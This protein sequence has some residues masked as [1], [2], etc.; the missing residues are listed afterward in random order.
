MATQIFG[1]LLYLPE[2]TCLREFPSPESLKNKIII[3]TK[4]PKEYL[5][6]RSIKD[7]TSSPVTEGSE[8][9]EEESLWGQD[10]TDSVT[11]QLETE[12]KVRVETEIGIH[13]FALL[14]ISFVCLCCLYMDGRKK[15]IKMRE[16]LTHVMI[17]SQTSDVH[18]LTTNA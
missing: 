15:V 8:S 7:R 5:Q 1:D 6:S 4:P 18:H 11:D 12:E 10:S 14:F 9:S 17:T 16:V 3:S 13:I 2:T